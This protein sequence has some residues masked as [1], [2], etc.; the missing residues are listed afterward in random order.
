MLFFNLN[1]Q[2]ELSSPNQKCCSNLYAY[3]PPKKFQC[4]NDYYFCK[5]YENSES[6]KGSSCKKEGVSKFVNSI[7]AKY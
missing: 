1:F 4:N 3:K 6:E 5:I 7:T 2:E